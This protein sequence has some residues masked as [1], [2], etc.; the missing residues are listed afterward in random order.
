MIAAAPLLLLPLLLCSGCAAPIKAVVYDVN[1]LQKEV[2]DVMTDQGDFIEVMDGL[3]FRK[4]KLRKISAIFISP[5]ETLSRDG[6]LYYQTEMWLVD[7][8]KILVYILPDGKRSSSYVNV[9]TA[10]VAKANGDPYT[11]KLKDV[12]E[13][14]FLVPQ[15]KK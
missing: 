3:A 14:R 4:I 2:T 9:N 15:K 10:I 8:T 1:G 11:I 5:G 6:H 12:K 7:G 13:I